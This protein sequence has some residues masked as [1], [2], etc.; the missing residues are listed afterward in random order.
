MKQTSKLS[1][2]LALLPSLLIQAMAQTSAP[3]ANTQ[4]P[5]GGKVVGGQATL[6]SSGN[7]LNVNQA[8]QR[9]VVEWNT[10]N[11]GS[12]ARVNFNQPSASAVTLNRVLDMN[13]SQILGSIS[14]TGQVFISNP[15]GVIFGTTAQVD[16]GGL[17]ATTKGISNADFMS[18]KT[19]FEG[20]GQAG[21]VINQG[22]LQAALGGYIALL[23]PQ[24]R[25]EGVI[26]AREG[27]VALT[28]GDKTTLEFNGTRLVSVIIDR[29]VIDALVE[30][31]QLI[32][33][34]GGFVV[35]S[36]RSANALLNSVIKQTGTIEAPSLVQRDG[37][38]LL[39]GGEKG[40]VSA[41]GVLNVSGTQAGTTGGRLVVT[42]DK[43]VIT[44]NA[45]LDATGQTG[46]GQINVG[47]GWQGQDPTIRQANAT[48]VEAGA[49]LDASAIQ[50]GN[51]GE[52]VVWSDTQKAGGMTQVAGDLKAR[53]GASQGNGLSLIHI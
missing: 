41:G 51:G 48:R 7:T 27:T 1:F 15:N 28:A 47:G 33:A 20:N 37:R 14:A 26:V 2:T 9:G 6:Q 17:V 42:G 4:L 19:T 30:N 52:I 38:I 13:A 40:V 35:M 53:G 16:V 8:T 43:V 36:A 11:V 34:D 23:A 25:N 39:E 24:V 44:E 3:I 45:L 12:Q 5:T 32:R 49:R 22:T 21:S 31:K 29:P 46:G 50:S 10:F 18:G